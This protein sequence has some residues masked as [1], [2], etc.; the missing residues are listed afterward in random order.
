MR[1]DRHV[2]G[3]RQLEKRYIVVSGC[4]LIGIHCICN[5]ESQI[6]AE[7]A[8]SPDD[9][10]CRIVPAQHRQE[11]DD[12]LLESHKIFRAIGSIRFSMLFESLA[13]NGIFPFGLFER[14]GI[15]CSEVYDNGV[16]YPALKIV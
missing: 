12:G 8:I 4:F 15:V 7:H 14:A 10:G 2:R 5:R 1:A 16:G 6:I 9:M 13:C 11:A 3:I